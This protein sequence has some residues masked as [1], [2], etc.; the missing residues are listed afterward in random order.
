MP[1][2][3][4][5]EKYRFTTDREEACTA[6]LTLRIPPSIKAEL[7]KIDGVNDKIRDFLESLVEI[8]KSKSA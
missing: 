8:E 6:N 5:I 4:H 2:T 3:D 7:K 1:R